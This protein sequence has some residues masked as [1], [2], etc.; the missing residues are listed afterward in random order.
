MDKKKIAVVAN[1]ENVGNLFF[2]LSLIEDLRAAFGDRADVFRV[3]GR[4]T[5]ID[6]A[7]SGIGSF[8]LDYGNYSHVDWIVLAGPTFKKGLVTKH[9]ALLDNVVKKNGAKLVLL[10]AGCRAYSDEETTS[11]RSFL[12]EYEPYAIS[13]RDRATFEA[14]GD[15]AAYAH[16]GICSAFYSALHYP[17]YDTPDLGDYITL[18]YD[19]WKEPDLSALS[20]TPLESFIAELDASRIRAR[21]AGSLEKL[22]DVLSRHPREIGG[23]KLIRP[24]H[25]VVPTPTSYLLSRPNKFMS[26]NPYAYL[27]IYRNTRLTLSNRVHACVPTLAYGNPAM[28]TARTNRARLFERVGL[29][30]IQERPVTLEGE[31]VREEHRRFVEFLRSI[32]LQ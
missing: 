23:V 12:Q 7:F 14:Y 5:L 11:V 8:Y 13:T 22:L 17:G 26:I 32:P 24:V 27:N 10:S 29:G 19:G 25:S 2:E 30:R 31:L 9:D 6:N 3:D 18:S 4:N 28:L 15:L 21:E 20:G 1:N 16:D